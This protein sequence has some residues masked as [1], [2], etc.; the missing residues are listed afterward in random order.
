MGHL[1]WIDVICILVKLYLMDFIGIIY[2][3]MKSPFM[4]LGFYYFYRVQYV[5]I[6]KH[7]FVMGENV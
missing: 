2:F 7:G 6:V 3:Y 5:I 1:L 4:L